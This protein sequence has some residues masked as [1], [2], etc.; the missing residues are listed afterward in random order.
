M[1][2]YSK[3]RQYYRYRRNWRKYQ[4]SSVKRE[5][6][7][8]RDLQFYSQF[9]DEGNLCFDIGANIGDKTEVFLRLG[10]VVV[11]VEPQESCWRFLQRRF[12]N[13]NVKIIPKALDKSIGSKE[14]FIDRSHTIS[15]MSWQWISS[16]RK[17][18]R[19]STH[20]WS[21]RMIAETTTL[22][23]LIEEYGNPAFCKIDVEGF[24]FEVLQ[25]LS[26]PIM[27][28]SFEFVPEYLAPVLSC[29]EHL[30]KLGEMTFNYCLGDSTDFAL[31]SWADAD[32]IINALNS[33]PNELTVQGDVYVRSGSSEFER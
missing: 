4:N 22:D 16:V 30:S 18:G 11:A 10:A 6:R 28:I 1:L 15:S 14:F 27:A 3:L 12:Q 23:V 32:E 25:G 21:D 31:S 26:K 2:L 20:K 24:E 17:S 33:L 7:L 29:V 5:E 9:I 8:N 13:D 19:F